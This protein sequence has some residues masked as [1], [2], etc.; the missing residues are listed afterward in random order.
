MFKSEV[1]SRTY[2]DKS[3]IISDNLYNIIIGL[4]LLWG[5]AANWLMVTMIPTESLVAINPF[6]FLIAYIACCFA[7]VSMFAGSDNPVVSFIGYNLVV[8]PFGFVLNMFLHDISSTIIIQALEVTALVTGIMMVLGALFPAFFRRISGALCAAL[9]VSIIVEL[10]LIFVFN[11]DFVVM[12]YIVA[13]IFC[14]YIGYDWGR[15]QAIPKTLDN[16]I[17]SA[18]SLYMDIVNLFVRFVSI[19]SND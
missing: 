8:V 10:L 17:D 1:F 12:D 18:A 7:G 16:A 13:I 11:R 2:V 15:A 9:V 14:G 6:V 4:T 19:F 3:K 5:F